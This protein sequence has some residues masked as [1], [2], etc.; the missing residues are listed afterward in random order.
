MPNL[1]ESANWDCEGKDLF[2]AEMHITS[3]KYAEIQTL[4]ELYSN[5]VQLSRVVS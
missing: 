2:E 5:K 1:N 3:H 4:S